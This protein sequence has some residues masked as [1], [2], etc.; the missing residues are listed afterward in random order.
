MNKTL[1]KKLLIEYKEGKYRGLTKRQA[2]SLLKIKYTE[3][4]IRESL[5]ILND[6]RW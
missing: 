1:I 4:S 2:F 3:L 5:S 6:R